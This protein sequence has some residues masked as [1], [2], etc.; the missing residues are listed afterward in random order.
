VT[1]GD[2]AM[3]GAGSTIT[4]DIDSD[5]LAVTRAELKSIPGAAKRY[6]EKKAAEKAAKGK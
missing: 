6:R 4:A 5:A 2:G 3:V 1:V